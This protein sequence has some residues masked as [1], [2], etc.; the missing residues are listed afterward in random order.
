MTT[1]RRHTRIC[2]MCAVWLTRHPSQ[3][4]RDCRPLAG[5]AVITFSSNIERNTA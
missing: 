5:D 4:C 3:I 1:R 2:I